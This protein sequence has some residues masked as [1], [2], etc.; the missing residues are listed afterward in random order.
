M[1]KV[2]DSITDSKSECLP[3]TRETR[4]SNY[5]YSILCRF[6]LNSKEIYLQQKNKVVDKKWKHG[7]LAPGVS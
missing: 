1:W 6:Q 5:S 7:Y 3:E 4:I 2:T